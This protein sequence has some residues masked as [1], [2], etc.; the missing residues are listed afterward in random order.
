M[1]PKV[2]SENLWFYS[3]IQFHI[4]LCFN[5]SLKY[6]HV[7]VITKVLPC[8]SPKTSDC[9]HSSSDNQGSFPARKKLKPSRA[10][11]LN[12]GSVLPPQGHLA[13]SGVIFGVPYWGGVMWV[14]SK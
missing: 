1:Y 9:R 13:M 7:L 5:E 8:P 2:F 12:W 6:W 14:S 4:I 11:V 3:F 10:V